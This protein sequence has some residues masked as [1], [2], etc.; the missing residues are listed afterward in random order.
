MKNSFSFK[1]KNVLSSFLFALLV[2][3][4]YGLA[5]LHFEDVIA[6]LAPDFED[7]GRLDA[8]V[9][10]L[11]ILTAFVFIQIGL[12]AR[13]LKLTFKVLKKKDFL[14][15]LKY[16]G[17]HFAVLILTFS[18]F[19]FLGIEADEDR[20]KIQESLF[21]NQGIWLTILFV[22]VLVPIFEESLF[23]GF[24]FADMRR[25]LAFWFPFLVSST[26]FAALHLNGQAG[27]QENL[28]TFTVIFS[29]SYFMT[30]TFEK[31]KNLWVP[32][33]F[34]SLHNLRAVL[35]IFLVT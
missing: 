1:L 13:R 5:L 29:L 33:I 17:I 6:I 21:E 22:A 28:Y 11:S 24:F 35:V 12:Y 8:L 23:R 14:I 34:H 26:F 3:F 7:S 32:V 2:I 20:Q 27:W 18:L 10:I 30:L 4:V 15:I 19:N 25:H 31:T 9:P 16:F